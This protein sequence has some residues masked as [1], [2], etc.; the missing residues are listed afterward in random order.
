MLK[1]LDTP[2]RVV[3]CVTPVG[4]FSYDGAKMIDA[5]ASAAQAK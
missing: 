5:V 1:M 2:T 3:L 4:G